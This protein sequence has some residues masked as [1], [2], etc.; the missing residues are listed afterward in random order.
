[1]KTMLRIGF[2]TVAALF[3]LAPSAYAIQVSYTL[4]EVGG[5]GVVM[6][7]DPFELEERV[8]AD[9]GTY[10][11]SGS[12]LSERT[13]LIGV[14]SGFRALVSR[15]E[16]GFSPDPVFENP[17]PDLGEEPDDSDL[18]I[19]PPGLGPV[20]LWD[21]VTID[22]RA[23]GTFETVAEI[24]GLDLVN[25][26][27]GFVQFDWVVT[28]IS[29][30]ALDAGLLGQVTV[31][32]AR[33]VTTLGFTGDSSIP[34]AFLHDPTPGAN[35]FI[36]DV[37]LANLQVESFLVPFDFNQLNNGENPLINVDFELAVE[38]RLNVT[39]DNNLGNFDA[40]FNADFSNTATLTNV[41]VLNSAEQPILNASVFVEGTT[42]SL[43]AV[44]EPSS[45]V[46]L[47]LVGCAG[48]I[49]RRRRVSHVH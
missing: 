43:V 5:S 2:L 47:T 8:F 15:F 33:S 22:T 13:G 17:G 20:T 11:F 40:L 34:D 25:D 18:G 1:M 27:T 4:N 35:G 12:V 23:A 45:M 39:N 16:Q 48:I 37:S 24:S 19:G 42:E 21:R 31:E 44:P 14:S 38:T 28:G 9:I 26:S 49:R 41:T 3:T 6:G 32:E 30:L 7:G 29:N 36:N 10:Q 46:V